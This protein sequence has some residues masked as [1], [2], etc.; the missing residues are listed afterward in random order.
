MHRVCYQPIDLHIVVL[1]QR[2]YYAY[3]NVDAGTVAEWLAADSKG[4]FYNQRIKSDAV[5]GRF[6]CRD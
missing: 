2:P 3:C 5:A 6:A 1:L 4:R